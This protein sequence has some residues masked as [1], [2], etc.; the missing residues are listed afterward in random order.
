MIRCL[1]D[2]QVT[3][4]DSDAPLQW[5]RKIPQMLLKVIEAHNGDLLIERAAELLWP[6]TPPEKQKRNFKVTL[7]RLRK[8]L[9]PKMN[10]AYGSSYLHIRDNRL[11]LDTDLCHLDSVH[12][13]KLCRRAEKAS[14]SDDVHRAKACYQ[15]ALALY[16][17]D[18][19]PHDLY[20][21]W[22]ETQRTHLR[23]RCLDAAFF[24]AMLLEEQKDFSAALDCLRRVIA[25]DP[26]HETAYCRLMQ[27]YA[28]QGDTD[29]VRKVYADCCASLAREIDTQP[30]PKTVHVFETCL[31]S[32]AI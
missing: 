28:R 15:E 10:K 27:L 22:S 7:H 6:E 23:N 18:F 19:L 25:M 12:F 30:C 26:L 3:A 5:D 13:E 4:G 9:E 16:L 21:D 8:I 11:V 14:Q 31:A 2:F 17:G 20:D 1:G 24:L 29:R 32:T